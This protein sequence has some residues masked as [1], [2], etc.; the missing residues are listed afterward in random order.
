VKPLDD[1]GA[2]SLYSC[3]TLDSSSAKCPTSPETP[4]LSDMLLPKRSN[5]SA[6]PA[7]SL[8]D[9]QSG[10]P[11]TASEDNAESDA[12]DE[13]DPEEATFEEAEEI[14]TDGD[15]LTETP[16]ARYA[17]FDQGVDNDNRSVID[18]ETWKMAHISATSRIIASPRLPP[19]CPTDPEIQTDMDHLRALRLL[20]ENPEAKPSTPR[21]PHTASGLS[22]AE[23]IRRYNPEYLEVWRNNLP[24]SDT[25]HKGTPTTEWSSHTCGTLSNDP[26][27]DNPLRV[28][29]TLVSLLRTPSLPNMLGTEP[30]EPSMSDAKYTEAPR[31]QSPASVYHDTEDREVEIIPETTVSENNEDADIVAPAEPL[32][33]LLTGIAHARS[34]SP[35]PTT[36]STIR[37]KRSRAPIVPT[38]Q[39]A[40]PSLVFPPPASEIPVNDHTEQPK[41]GPETQ[42]GSKDSQSF[43]RPRTPRRPQGP[44]KA[45]QFFA[46]WLARRR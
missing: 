25:Q 1:N 26:P 40:P 22:L 35:D 24:N 28:D 7:P 17:T 2:S 16:D 21:P 41:S 23:R 12:T 5:T 37:Q 45:A 30:A 31:S 34:L 6:K 19:S 15:A 42:S 8:R 3:H 46:P 43:R 11:S 39:Q 18:G 38:Q 20:E 9:S 13:E 14:D 10:T 33:S 36:S 4:S 27:S 32:A 29:P 44:S